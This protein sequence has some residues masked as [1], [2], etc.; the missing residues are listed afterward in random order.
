MMNCELDGDK[1]AIRYHLVLLLGE[2]GG[3]LWF[4]SS[5]QLCLRPIAVKATAA[6]KRKVSVGA[7]MR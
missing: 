2:P 1:V 3:R 6:N 7:P 5:A 4:A